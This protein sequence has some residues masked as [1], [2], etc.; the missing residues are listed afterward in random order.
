MTNVQGMTLKQLNDVLDEMHTVYP[1]EPDKTR[2]GDFRDINM[3]A[4]R[5]VQI[6]TT[7]ESTGISIVLT[8]GVDR[9]GID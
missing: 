1:F 6:V 5:Q 8:K 7:D 3:A 9:Y 2:L 4:S